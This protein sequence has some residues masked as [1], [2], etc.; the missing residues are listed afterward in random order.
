MENGSLTKK[1]F[2]AKYDARM[3]KTRGKLLYKSTL[4]TSE[5]ALP[6]KYKNS[7]GIGTY[8]NFLTIVNILCEVTVDLRRLPASSWTKCD[9]GQYY[10]ASYTI[11]LLFGPELVLK[12][13]STDDLVLGSANAR[14]T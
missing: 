5:D 7:S 1:S 11:G 3:F 10:Q 4:F 2:V 8:D 13:M 9:G 14:Y 6:P 12:F